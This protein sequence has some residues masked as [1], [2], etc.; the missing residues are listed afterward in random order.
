MRARSPGQGIARTKLGRTANR[1]PA[2]RGLADDIV[3]I[4]SN[5]APR[6]MIVGH[7]GK[8]GGGGRKALP[9]SSKTLFAGLPAGIDE[10]RA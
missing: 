2:A 4:V 6:A 8:G 5:V 7:A 1:S 3:P 9:G 10:N